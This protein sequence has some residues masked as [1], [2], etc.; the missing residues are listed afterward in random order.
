[1][2]LEA[3]TLQLQRFC[4]DT[5]AFLYNSDE[6]RD[7]DIALEARALQYLAPLGSRL[8]KSPIGAVRRTVNLISI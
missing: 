5:A 4:R 2:G 8:Y 1:M 6:T 3:Q 7:Y